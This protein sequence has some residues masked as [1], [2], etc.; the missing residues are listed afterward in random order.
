MAALWDIGVPDS[1]FER[2]FCISAK[3]PL[4]ICSGC[5]Y[6][7]GYEIHT[8]RSDLAFANGRFH[9]LLSALSD[10]A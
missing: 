8:H 2:A 10:C 3:E 7:N 4:G 9:Q 6:H 5:I 1:E